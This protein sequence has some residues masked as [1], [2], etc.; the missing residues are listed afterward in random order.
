MHRFFSPFTLLWRHRDLVVQFTLREVHLRHKG[1]RLGHFWA[2]IS[3]LTM[4]LLYFFIFGLIM[5][6]KFGALP[7][8]TSIDYAVALFLGLS[9]FHVV[10]ETIGAAPI[11]IANQPNFVKKVVFPLEII[12]I[13]N[14][15][16]SVYHSLLSILLL[17][18][19]APFTHGGLAW[20]G[21][22]YIPV[23][24]VPL[25]LTALGISYGLSALGVF[26]RD[27]SQLTAF[28]S[29][30]I[31]FASAVFYSPAKVTPEIWA[32]L[33]YNPL[34]QII[35]QARKA[36]L[37]NQPVDGLAILYAY[38]C[39]F[40]VLILGYALFRRLRPYFAEVI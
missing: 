9:F 7:G 29:T 5:G 18:C 21:L 40:A 3:P 2:L 14:V 15:C 12:P 35:V 26:L 4:L 25:A 28:L 19:V 38:G 36:V 33:K 10:T 24:I 32:L 8:E 27:V 1:S 22:F 17:L 37:W 23:L 6:G 20:S 34:L 13:S 30:A 16:V 11:L 31:M 39:S